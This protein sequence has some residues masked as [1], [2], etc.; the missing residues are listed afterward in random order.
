M[1]KR[2]SE[3]EARLDAQ[4]SSANFSTCRDTPSDPYR[5]PA[6]RRQQLILMHNDA[7]GSEKM[8]LVHRRVQ[9][10]KARR[11]NTVKDS[12][13]SWTMIIEPGC[14]AS[15]L[16]QSQVGLQS[17]G[18]RD[19]DRA[20]EQMCNNHHLFHVQFKALVRSASPRESWNI[21]V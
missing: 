5:T 17:I 9:S 3:V 16:S 10:S 15:H 6:T 12:S 11:C 4:R 13:V 18:D 14:R 8:R 2:K 7:D 20:I 1:G 19:P 21:R